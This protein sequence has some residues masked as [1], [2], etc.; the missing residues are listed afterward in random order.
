MK[1]PVLTLALATSL[2]FGTI[3]TQATL[4]KSVET[5][6]QQPFKA[7]DNKVFNSINADNIY[8]NIDY[9]SKTPRVAGTESE[10]EAVQYI[11]SQFESYGY[12]AEIQPFTFFGYTPPH[13]L[14]L[15]VN[16]FDGELDP[17]T[18]TY[19]VSGNISGELVYAGLGKN[20]ELQDKDLTGKIALIKRGELTFADKVLNA[21]ER[22]ATGVIIFNNSEGSLGGTLGGPNEDFVP[23]VSLSKAEG[24]AL[25]AQLNSGEELTASLNVEGAKYGESESYNV[26]ATKE[27][28]NKRKATDDIIVV[29]SHHDSVAGA[30]G[31]NDDASGTAMTLELARVMK[32]VPS[33]TEIR[34]ITFG[35]EENGLLGS[36]HYV[37]N[38]SEDE[39]ERTIA[40][41]NLDM[42]GSKDA[43]DLV[44]LTLDGEPN[45]VTELAQKSSTL[46]NGEPTPFGQGGRSDHVPFAEAGIP[47][48]LFIHSPTEPWYH[49]PEDTIDKI[50][51]EK[52][53]DVAEIVALAVFDQARF[54]SM[55]PKPKKSPKVKAAPEM[56]Q[57]QDIR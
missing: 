5:P 17:G 20:D 53:Q 2:T 51:K 31:A 12:D 37:E 4:A 6:Q 16:G 52:L 7:L 10:F 27:P 47:A 56:K 32:N 48:A 21:A 19:A 26:I 49:S 33:D 11:K 41:F 8:D 13:T 38:L 28:T 22:G 29:G 43:G 55:G 14:E 34:F 57:K 15:A 30:P 46:L 25:L 1:K 54:N 23:V 18:F 40:N 24:E 9:L 45:L 50:S 3:G 42:V 35:A 44:M 36:S 39:I